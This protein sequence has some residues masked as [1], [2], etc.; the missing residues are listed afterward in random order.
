MKT[1]AAFA[2]ALFVLFFAL[3]EVFRAYEARTRAELLGI[4]AR[5][6]PTNATLPE[7]KRFLAGHARVVVSPRFRPNE[8]IGVMRQ[9]RLDRW[10][11][12]RQVQIVIKIDSDGRYSSAEIRFYYTF[13]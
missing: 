1:L 11:L 2:T 7:T 6:L 12:D 3:P 13:L 10:M 8:V 4:V 9:S 5:E